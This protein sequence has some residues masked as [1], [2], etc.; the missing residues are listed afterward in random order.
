MGKKDLKSDMIELLREDEDLRNI[1]RDICNTNPIKKIKNAVFPQSTSTKKAYI[2]SAPVAE[3]TFPS[4][5]NGQLV[6]KTTNEKKKSDDSFGW[7]SKSNADEIKELKANLATNE[8]KIAD[9]TSDIERQKSRLAKAQFTIDGLERDNLRLKRDVADKDAAYRQAALK[10]QNA[11]KEN[12]NLQESIVSLRNESVKMQQ[13]IRMQEQQLSERFSEGW[14]L[15]CA[16]QKVSKQSRDRLKGVFVK[17]NDFSSF[18]CGGAQDKSLGKIWDEIKVCLSSG[19]TQDADVLWDIF[20]YAVEL[21]NSAKT[22]RIY[23]I[24]QVNVG[25][26]FDLD[27]HTLAAG[28]RAQGNVREV[29]LLGYKN[30]Y[31]GSVERK[32][33]VSV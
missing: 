17:E 23:E 16:Y 8:R 13:T 18:I 25:E 24:M 15:F 6:A 11:E 22:E 9:L 30:I 4:E 26:A 20:E 31:V 33:I 19:N 29:Y 2:E 1:I 28:S 32:S 3:R 10:L 21:V 5:G 27:L 7:F 14:D 12:G